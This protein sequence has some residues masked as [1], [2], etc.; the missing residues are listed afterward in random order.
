V[1]RVAEVL[2]SPQ[3]RIEAAFGVWLR[4][5][6]QRYLAGGAP[7]PL[8]MSL[9]EMGAVFH[10]ELLR[11]LVEATA[12]GG[13]GGAGGAGGRRAPPGAP[14]PAVT[15]DDAR[16]GALYRR[17]RVG[18]TLADARAAGVLQGPPPP[19]PPRA[20]VGFLAQDA[21]HLFA[22]GAGAGA[23]AAA[24]GRWYNAPLGAL[25]VGRR[26][27]ENDIVV[28]FVALAGAGADP[29]TDPTAVRA[30]FKIRPP[31]HRLWAAARQRG[32]ARTLSRG[33]VCATR[34]REELAALV[35]RLRGA[36]ARRAPPPPGALRLG[37]APPLRPPR[38]LAAGPPHPDGA[39]DPEGDGDP[40][41]DGDLAPADFGADEADGEGAPADGADG[42]AE[43][44]DDPLFGE[45]LALSVDLSYAARF[46]RA[47]GRFPPAGTLCDTLR[48]HLLALEEGAR[49][50]SDGMTAGLRWLYLFCDKTPSIS[51]LVTA[52][53]RGTARAEAEVA[54]DA[55]EPEGA[56]DA[57]AAV[58]GPGGAAA[59][60][61]PGG[62]AAAAAAD[63]AGADA[64]AAGA[65]AAAADAD[66]AGP[67]TF[68]DGEGE[69]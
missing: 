39:G 31:L 24:G 48:L 67:A 18:V 33:A 10:F 22:A 59:A 56:A 25:G 27:K 43:G 65:D 58:A 36:L 40:E 34:P 38:A 8:E 20:L 19:L 46:D 35:A 62:V 37:R 15:S 4:A 61:G 6:E 57:D 32:D 60:A 28:G 21:V 2:G 42:G 54:A 1:V 26:A 66:A 49:A 41:A 44:G 23:G 55:A 45:G 9:V 52:A 7:A 50:P 12:A 5:Y 63:A 11:R 53:A 16:V 68:E 14:P 13:G 3:R 17:F 64:D 29:G 51:A 69:I 30:Q 47:K